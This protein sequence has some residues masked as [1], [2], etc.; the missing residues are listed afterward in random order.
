MDAFIF[1]VGDRAKD[2]VSG[3][4]GILVS[5]SQHLYGCNRY[6]L[7]PEGHKDGKPLDG[8]WMDEDALI[9]VA[10]GALKPRVRLGAVAGQTEL[11]R[12]GGAD[13]PSSAP[14]LPRR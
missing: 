1:D 2:A 4:E 6:W 14:S 10:K 7:Q 3:M 12:T 9:L 13:L 5:R 11:R 8:C